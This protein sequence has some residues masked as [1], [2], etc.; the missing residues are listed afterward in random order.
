MR[1]LI[2]HS[3]FWKVET[4]FST[5]RKLNYCQRQVN[6]LEWWQVL[7]KVD[8]L[9]N[10]PVLKFHSFLPVLMTLASVL[11]VHILNIQ[12]QV[13]CHSVFWGKKKKS[14]A[15]YI[16]PFHKHYPDSL[17]SHYFVKPCGRSKHKTQSLP[18]ANL[19]SLGETKAIQVWETPGGERN[20][21]TALWSDI[22]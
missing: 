16:Y 1:M 21:A 17:C 2:Q 22:K 19:I 3:Y 18:C 13:A 9:P 5:T 14:N 12:L 11:N 6:N 10:V 8:E 7:K 15:M 20:T 4:W